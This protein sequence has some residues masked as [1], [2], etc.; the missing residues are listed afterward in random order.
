MAEVDATS[1]FSIAGSL[2]T[3]IALRDNSIF[4]RPRR[5]TYLFPSGQPSR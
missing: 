4:D 3:Q 1:Q 2:V 5:W